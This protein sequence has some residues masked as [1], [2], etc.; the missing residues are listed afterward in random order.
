MKKGITVLA[1]IDDEELRREVAIAEGNYKLQ[2][3][4]K[5]DRLRQ[6]RADYGKALQA[7]DTAQL[8]Y[9][10]KS[11]LYSVG[12]IALS[13]LEASRNALADANR[14][15]PSI[16]CGTESPFSPIPSIFRSKTPS[17]SWKN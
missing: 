16:A 4:T 8:D 10:R 17:R 9:D 2:I 12:G 11:A 7:R 15:F 5:E 3:A 14:S 1:R 6:E 13:E